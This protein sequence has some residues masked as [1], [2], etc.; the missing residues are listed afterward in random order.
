[1]TI[2]AEEG[3]VWQNDRHIRSS[4]VDY[5]VVMFAESG[6]RLS[7]GEALDY[8]DDIESVIPKLKKYQTDLLSVRRPSHLVIEYVFLCTSLPAL[9]PA[10]RKLPH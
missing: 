8:Y 10:T 5:A 2:M 4:L 6:A 9:C 7:N 3:H 1:M